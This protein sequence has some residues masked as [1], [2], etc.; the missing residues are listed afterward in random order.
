MRRTGFTLIE[1]LVVIAIL[2]ILAAILLPS[3]SRARE[4]ARRSSCQNNLKQ[5][6][7]VLAMYAEESRGRYPRL[8]AD[9]PWGNQTPLGCAECNNRAALAPKMIGLYPNYLSDL[10]ILVCP[11][12]PD[13]SKDNPLEI[14]EALPGQ[15]CYYAG[16]PSRADVSYLYYGFLFDKCE[17]KDPS[18]NAAMLAPSGPA[19]IP[20][21]M[22]YFMAMISYFPGEAFLDGPL[23][24]GNPDNDAKLDENQAQDMKHAIISAMATPPNQPLG[25]VNTNTVMRLY[26]G[27][28][29]ILITDIDSPEKGAQAESRIPVMWDIVSTR[30]SGV[31]QFNH[32]PGGAN[33]LYMDGHVRFIPYPTAFPASKGFAVVTSLFQLGV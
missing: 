22:A 7:T 30:V 33:V 14:L 19:K 32:V 27:I 31:A 3:L 16:M 18:I 4:A 6:G 2:G 13:S 29:R 25:N 21:Q 20:A 23:G 10:N 12:D 5:L 9:E 28:H 17:D 11:S 26:D 1:L 15:H 8:H 24:D